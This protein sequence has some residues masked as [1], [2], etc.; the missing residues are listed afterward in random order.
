MYSREIDAREVA[1]LLDEERKKLAFDEL[2]VIAPPKALGR[3]REAIPRELRK[4]VTREVDKDLTKLPLHELP[5]KIRA[6]L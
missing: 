4:M 1:R 5:E 2:V 6:L 3:L